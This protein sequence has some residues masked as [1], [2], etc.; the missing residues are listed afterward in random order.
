MRG[1]SFDNRL[2]LTVNRAKSILFEQ[3]LPTDRASRAPLSAYHTC[4]KDFAMRPSQELLQHD[5]TR[6]G[7]ANAPSRRQTDRDGGIRSCEVRSRVICLTGLAFVVLASP[8]S[9]IADDAYK[10]NDEVEVVSESARMKV[11]DQTVARPAK[12]TTARVLAVQGEWLWTSVR[13]DGTDVQG[14][15]HVKYVRVRPAPAKSGRPDAPP[16][17]EPMPKTGKPGANARA[18]TT[19][20]PEGSTPR[21][22]PPMPDDGK[23]EP[24]ASSPD[25]A[26]AQR[27]QKAGVLVELND[28]Q[29]I[30]GIDL[31]AEPPP[32][33]LT[34]S[35]RRL[36][37]LKRVR[38]AFSP[39]I[40]DEHVAALK[41]CSELQEADLMLC[42]RV[43]DDGVATL[44]TLTRLESLNLSGTAVTD[45][46]VGSLRRLI[47]LTHLELAGTPGIRMSITDAA[48]G[49][50]AR[51]SGLQRLNLN[52]TDLTDRG[53]AR[54]TRLSEL[55]EL[56]LGD[57]LITNLGLGQ[58]KKLEQLERLG[59][60]FCTGLTEEG[61]LD[62]SDLE[63]KHL[64]ITFMPLS[65]VGVVHLCAIDTLESL[66]VIETGLTEDLKRL[67]QT[68]IP[69]CRIEGP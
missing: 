17:P 47:R 21:M 12:G 51:F 69:D 39:G 60:G 4:G 38:F 20:A 19:I 23:A 16:L 62:L 56:D 15:L 36:R 40:T 9:L 42:S 22:K 68:R 3:Q 35:L 41:N 43:S 24:D 53:L 44:G 52:S 64:D 57:T 37:H 5:T 33:D 1:A 34:E 45:Q 63:L 66:K 18:V 10:V 11:G 7:K 25:I 27:L 49:H 13:V 48:T 28:L 14:W 54:L 59:L 32:P 29:Q 30:V 58:L 8:C 31:D 50:L 6:D 67:I 26:I 55:R 65:T 2:L 61:L 46:G